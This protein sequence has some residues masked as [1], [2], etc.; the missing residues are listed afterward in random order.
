MAKTSF[1]SAYRIWEKWST[2]FMSIGCDETFCLKLVKL[3]FWHKN[4]NPLRCLKYYVRIN[5]GVRGPV[6]CWYEEAVEIVINKKVQ[7]ILEL[8]NFH[9]PSFHL[10]RMLPSVLSV[11]Y[12]EVLLYSRE[13]RNQIPLGIVDP[14]RIAY[15]KS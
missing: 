1:S 5:H 8:E 6:K 10:T 2:R 3:L 9:Y 7:K 15:I 4:R 12:A 14:A 11:I 13:F